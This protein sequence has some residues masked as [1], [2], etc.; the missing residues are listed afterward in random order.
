MSITA[1]ELAQRLNL[2]E[3]AVS[4]A[5]NNKPG[6]SPATRQLVMEAAEKYGY[7]F[8]RI[9]GKHR[10]TGTI[11]F[12]VFRKHGAVVSET[13]FFTELRDSIEKTCKELGY[14]LSVQELS[15]DE[16]LAGKIDDIVYSDC[17]GIL[18]QGTEMHL[19]DFRTF[20]QIRL[21][22]VLLDV[23]LSGIKRD[24]V[25]INN[26]QGAFL[27]T[28]HLIRSRKKQP[29]YLR[30]SYSICNFDERADGFYKAVR[31]HGYPVSQ[32]IVHRLSPSID[33]AYADLLELLR[34]G[35]P[36]AECYF[37]D[38]DN[39]AIGAMRA[40]REMGYRLPEDIAIVGFDNIPMCN[41]TEPSLT[42]VNVPKQYL[43]EMAVRRLLEVQQAKQFVPLKIE[44]STNLVKRRSV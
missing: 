3:A 23:Y 17:I 6:V 40:F 35:E 1:K 32:S 14:R 5:L 13:P 42:T 11:V 9:S 10:R 15:D 39:I 33:G 22:I 28:D 31:K 21:P 4:I 7:D 38:N 27:A 30:S 44:V 20:A 18:L 19:E 43:G 37:A 34:G 25:L 41:Y 12:A 36:A 8:T 24:C 29:G 26:E 2:S 16:T